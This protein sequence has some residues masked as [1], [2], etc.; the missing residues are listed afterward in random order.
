MNFF[1]NRP[2]KDALYYFG[3]ICSIPHPS[4]HEQKLAEKIISLAKEHGLP[5]RMDNAGNV[6][7][8]RP[9]APGYENAP[10]I[11]LQGHI[12]MVPKAAA[13]KEFDFETQPLELI[14]ENGILRAN[15][16]TL[17]ADDGAGAA[18]ILALLF[19]FFILF[20][21]CLTHIS[22]QYIIQ[23]FPTVFFTKY[24]YFCKLTICIHWHTAMIQQVAII[25]LIQT[26][27]L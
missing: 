11:I 7:I 24:L 15:G 16:T 3:L 13:G 1:E 20:K 9:A 8:D 17:G 23:C 14:E 18:C 26:A 2:T 4:G 22:F 12:D 19:D 25:N 27:M 10:R 6:R 5:A 21:K